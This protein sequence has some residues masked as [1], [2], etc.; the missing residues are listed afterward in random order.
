MNKKLLAIG[1]ILVFLIVG[2]SGCFD[3]NGGQ[4][5][6]DTDKVEIVS[7]EVITTWKEIEF[8]DTWKDQYPEWVEK[9]GFYHDIPE[10]KTITV[11]GYEDGRYGGAQYKVKVEVRNIAGE[12]IDVEVKAKFYDENDNHLKTKTKEIKNIANSY[13]GKTTFSY[14]ESET[15]FDNVDSVKFNF[16]V[17]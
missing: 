2:L 4:I 12:I 13:T 10:K 14:G 5:S 9:S 7:Y 11:G 3:N 1:I 6:G 16:K 8:G 15:Y 17:I